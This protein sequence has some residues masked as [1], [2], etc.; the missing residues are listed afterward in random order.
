MGDR[1]SSFCQLGRTHT[2]EM[3]E[4]LK[5]E[6]ADTALNGSGAT[7]ALVSS[8]Q[9][10]VHRSNSG[11]SH[12]VHHHHHPK[13]KWL[14]CAF[15]L[16]VLALFLTGGRLAYNRSSRRP[17][18][19]A[20]AVSLKG[21]PIENLGTIYIP[22]VVTNRVRD[23]DILLQIP[24]IESAKLLE[25]KR[26]RNVAQTEE[27]KGL[28]PPFSTT[29]SVGMD[30][31]GERLWFECRLIGPGGEVIVCR[32]FPKR[33]ETLASGTDHVY[34]MSSSR[35]PHG[36]DYTLQ[37][38]LA[39]IGGE[40]G[41]PHSFVSKQYENISY[42]SRTVRVAVEDPGSTES[43]SVGH[44]IQTDDTTKWVS[45]T[46]EPTVN[47]P[48][49]LEMGHLILVGDS[50]MRGWTDVL[51]VAQGL[52]VPPLTVS[53]GVLSPCTR[54]RVSYIRGESMRA[55]YKVKGTKLPTQMR[56]GWTHT[57]HQLGQLS[58]LLRNRSEEMRV[59][60]MNYGSWDLRD[61]GLTEYCG[62][63]ARL[64]E[65]MER[66][67]L[68]EDAGVVWVWRATPAYSY[69][70]KTWRHGDMRTNE[71]IAAAN[72][73]A[74]KHLPSPR[75]HHHNTFAF[76]Y[77]LFAQS[78]DSHHYLCPVHAKLLH[79]PTCP[80]TNSNNVIISSGCPGRADIIGFLGTHVCPV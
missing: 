8:P 77:P 2:H 53:D 43:Y 79:P 5:V 52:D 44:Y 38:T 76:T 11:H 3:D 63:V 58:A 60:A 75:W 71:K 21:S 59:V 24:S 62:R 18:P 69:G 50:H 61:V 66:L 47:L 78:C 23:G 64:G 4:E 54:G 27:L 67:G 49:C 6:K 7:G 9:Q 74:R 17:S 14:I 32:V 20:Q 70:G 68:F 26:L 33:G 46:P 40:G 57:E 37:L 30:T 28:D 19:T 73:C 36:G 22:P 56:E 45:S 13:R 48:E 35:I 51:S 31:R 16:W 34:S 25:M 41:D 1:K 29:V 72:A 15:Q 80:M 65:T 55:T 10:P 42:P 12:T 39:H